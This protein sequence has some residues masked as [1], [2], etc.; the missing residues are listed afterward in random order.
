MR[1]VT[2]ALAFLIVALLVGMPA[3]V[4][5]PVLDGTLDG[6]EGNVDSD[7]HIVGEEMCAI[8][9]RPGPWRFAPLD[10]GRLR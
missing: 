7:D 2:A 6:S 4:A 9:E 10:V 5:D 3:A 8:P 1:A